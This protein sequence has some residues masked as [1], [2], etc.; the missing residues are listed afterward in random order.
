MIVHT[1]AVRKSGFESSSHGKLSRSLG[2][3]P[4]ITPQW[5][6]LAS[7]GK[8]ARKTQNSNTGQKN[9]PLHHL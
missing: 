1:T 6:W 9:I 8:G 7:E 5:R 3:L 2:V 4:S